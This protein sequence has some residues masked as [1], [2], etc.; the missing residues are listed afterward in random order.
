MKSWEELSEL[1]QL[2]DNPPAG[3][4][5]AVEIE[6]LRE[7]LAAMKAENEML[8]KMLKAADNEL[9]YLDEEVTPQ[10][11]LIPIGPLDV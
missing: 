10:A 11:P 3:G 9:D 7:S 2:M 8:R 4:A 5:Q 6:A 1:E